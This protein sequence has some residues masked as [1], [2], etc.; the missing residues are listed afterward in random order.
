MWRLTHEEKYRTYAWQFAT[1]LHDHARVNNG[2]SGYASLY[3]VNDKHHE[4]HQSSHLLA[5]TFK[6]LYLIFSDDDLVP[7]DQ[8]VFNRVGQ[9]LPISGKNPA[10][11]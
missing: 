4:N 2:A 6:Y 9:P 8:W 11:M 3:D 7:L 10:F 1:A 5:S